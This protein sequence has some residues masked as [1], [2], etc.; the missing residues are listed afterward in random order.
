MVSKWQSSFFNEDLGLTPKT[1]RFKKPGFRP[2][3]R[4]VAI[5]RERV[6]I[7]KFS[8]YNGVDNIGEPWE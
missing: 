3:L 7:S 8:P 2:N 5:L 1:F 4:Y 6:S